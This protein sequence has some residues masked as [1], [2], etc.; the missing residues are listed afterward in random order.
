M[1][2]DVLDEHASYRFGVFPEDCEDED[3]SFL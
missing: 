1:V 3:R 2:T